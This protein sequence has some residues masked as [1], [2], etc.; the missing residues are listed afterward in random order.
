MLYF[1]RFL[2]H[3][4][5]SIDKELSKS[6]AHLKVNV[7]HATHYALHCNIQHI[8]LS[9]EPYTLG[10]SGIASLTQPYP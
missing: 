10:G 7:Q 5:A 3:A 2:R 8:K 6:L 4:K 1:V 9:E